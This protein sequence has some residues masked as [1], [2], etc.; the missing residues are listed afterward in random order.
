MKTI[1]NIELCMLVLFRD[2]TRIDNFNLMKS[3]FPNL[4]MFKAID[5]KCDWDFI[6]NFF[7]KYE[8]TTKNL[9]VNSK[10]K[11]AR[12]ISVILFAKYVYDT[13][14]NGSILLEDDV[15]LPHNFNFKLGKYSN[16]HFVK[17][18]KWGE[19]YYMD[20]IGARKFLN[21][22][23]KNGISYHNDIFIMKFVKDRVFKI[24]EPDHL[25]CETNKGNIKTTEMSDLGVI[26]YNNNY[27]LLLTKLFDNENGDKYIDL[28]RL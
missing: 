21:A 1:G 24:I 19:G 8:I 12:W 10:G 15:L 25:I 18:S 2:Q 9:P 28:K 23:Y 20:Y 3:R 6:H 16:C 26:T 13:K 22:V 27:K 17:L 7:K 14:S 4:K 5:W 11:F